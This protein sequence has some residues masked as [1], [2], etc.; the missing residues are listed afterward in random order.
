MWFLSG[1]T[2]DDKYVWVASRCQL[3]SMDIAFCSSL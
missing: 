3:S 2:S 1:I